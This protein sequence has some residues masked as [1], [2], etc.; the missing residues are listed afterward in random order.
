MDTNQMVAKLKEESTNNTVRQDVLA[1]LACRKRSR[2]TLNVTALLQR[3]K[4]EGFNYSRSDYAGV[5]EW[6]CKL[7]VGRLIRTKRG[8]IKGLADIKYTFGSLGDTALGDKSPRSLKHRT[9]F[10]VIKAGRRKKLEVM[11]A[12]PASSSSFPPSDNNKTKSLHLAVG[13]RH[14]EITMPDSMSAVELLS[15]INDLGTK[16]Q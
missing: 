11:G 15:F 7:E 2:T 3:M 16:D 9:K 5:L 14:I 1:V 4:R 13:D 12:A 6:L 10:S 8:L